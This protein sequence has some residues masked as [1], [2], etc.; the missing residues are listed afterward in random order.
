MPSSTA[1]P[2]SYP[3][4]TETY[5]LEDIPSESVVIKVYAASL[6][7]RDHQIATGSYPAPVSA[8]T[9]L[10]PLSDASGVVVGVGREVKRFQPGDRVVSHLNQDWKF[11]EMLAEEMQLKALGGG[12]KDG[13]LSKYSLLHQ[14]NLIKIPDHLSFEQASTLTVAN[15]TAFHC[16]FGHERSLQPGQTVLIQ[17]TGGVSTSALQYSL[18]LGARPIVI[19]SSGEKLE[20]CQAL[21]VEERDCINYTE[22]KDWQARV[23]ELTEGRGVDHTIEIGGRNTLIKSLSCTSNQGC[24]WVVGYMDDFSSSSPPSSTQMQGLD[25]PKAILYT[26]AT[27]RGVMCGSLRLFEQ[28]LRSHS[29]EEKRFKRGLTNS[30]LLQPIVGKVFPFHQAKE[31]FECLGKGEFFGKVVIK[32]ADDE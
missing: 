11:G 5:R 15:L 14:D 29:N 31:A 21:G 4:E 8:K 20:R 10:I 1:T 17:G 3:R 26:Q 7:A 16:L 23:M 19:S 28:L 30:N 32:V 13:V 2:S 9:G 27:V 24:V 12:Q 18:S 22:V 25:I 6:N